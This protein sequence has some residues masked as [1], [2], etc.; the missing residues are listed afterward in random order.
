MIEVPILKEIR[1]YETKVVGPLSFRGLVC[2]TIAVACAYGAFAAQKFLLHMESPVGIICMIAAV[3]AIMFWIVKPYGMKLETY[4]KTA[5][6]DNML[7]PQKRPYKQ[8]YT[9]DVLFKGNEKYFE[10]LE[11]E[12]SEEEKDKPKKSK[13]PA[14]K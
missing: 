14:Y 8:E 7:A 4:L 12:K 11:E 1:T 13:T 3:P 2:G 6:I 5:F 9:Y 10:I